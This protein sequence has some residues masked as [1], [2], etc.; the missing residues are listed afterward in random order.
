ML[1][2]RQLCANGCGSRTSGSYLCSVC[3]RFDPEECRVRRLQQRLQE[4][5]AYGASG[6]P[7]EGTCLS[8]QNWKDRCLMGIP[9]VSLAFGPK[10]AC[11][12]EQE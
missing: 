7:I 5:R 4:L 6:Q 11:Y 8:C 12:L 3:A 1:A 9:E 10:C 2:S